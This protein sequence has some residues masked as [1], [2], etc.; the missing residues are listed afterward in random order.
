MNPCD[1][2]NVDLLRYL[3]NDLSGEELKHFR[4][5]LNS[6]AHCRDRLEREQALSSL[7]RDSRPLYSAP[8]ELRVQISAAIEG[9]SGR[10]RSRRHWWRHTLP[11]TLSWRMLVPAALVVVFCLISLPN[12]V[13]NVRAADYVETALTNHNR[14]LHGELSTE[15]RTSSPEAVTAW[16]A[17]KV[18]FQFRLPS[19]GPQANPTYELAGASLVE[20]RA[21][22]AAM[23]VYK[24]PT[25]TISLMVASSKSAV[26]AGG[27]EIHYG[28]LTFHYRNKDRFKVITWSNHDLSY[29]LVSSVASSAQESCMVCH[30][31]MADRDRFPRP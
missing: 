7:L 31:T 28:A 19:S 12:I 8:A 16:F 23:V 18:P 14:Y 15:I 25:E 10:D 3:D 9:H 20:Y 5:H 13:Q 24:A 26:V 6:C 27:D 30:Q 29:A 2:L 4:A 21:G 1:D 22:L 11:L 17:G